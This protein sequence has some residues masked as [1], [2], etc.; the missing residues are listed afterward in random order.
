MIYLPALFMHFPNYL[1]SIQVVDPRVDA[2]LVQNRDASLLSGRVELYH[3]RRDITR[4][5]DLGLALDCRADN[6]GMIYERYER[7]D[8][9]VI[10]DGAVKLRPGD[11]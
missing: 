1:H 9:V 3:S 2:N 10:C 6:F 7:D 4:R 8:D 5:D 11:V